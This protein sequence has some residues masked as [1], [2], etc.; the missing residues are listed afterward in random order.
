MDRYLPVPESG[1][2]NKMFFFQKFYV[3]SN[4]F[5]FFYYWLFI[6]FS[7]F[8]NSQDYLPGLEQAR[9]EFAVTGLSQKIIPRN[10]YTWTIKEKKIEGFRSGCPLTLLYNNPTL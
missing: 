10:S 1:F 7:I 5:I 3:K 2:Q 8:L 4:F 9:A 6:Y